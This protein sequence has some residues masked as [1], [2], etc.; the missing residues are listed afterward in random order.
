M[1]RPMTLSAPM[2]L[3]SLLVGVTGCGGVRLLSREQEIQIGTDA[4][5]DFEKDHP[6]ERGTAR[7]NLV[8]QIGQRVSRQA[9]PPE[10]P[11]EYKVCKANEVNAVAFPGGKIYLWTGLFSEVKEP[12]QLAWVASHE[13]AHVARQHVARELEK[14]LGYEILVGLLTDKGTTAR[15]IG[16]VVSQVLTLKYSRSAEQEADR[17]GMDYAAG[18]GYD[19]TAC[20]PVLQTFQRLGGGGGGTLGE[21]LSTHPSPESR[22]KDARQ[23][24]GEKHYTGKYLR[25]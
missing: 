16:G 6:V 7:A 25:P 14:S 10:Y 2:L 21:Y 18:A 3:V 22:L 12:D 4:A 13:T 1:R 23:Y 9:M 11:Y 17:L 8:T 20:I 5:A 19:P 15:T 24:L